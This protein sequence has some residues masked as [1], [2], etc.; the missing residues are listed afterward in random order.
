MGKSFNFNQLFSAMTNYGDSDH[1]VILLGDMNVC[2]GDT[3]DYLIDDNDSG[4]NLPLPED[5]QRWEKG[6]NKTNLQALT[7]KEAVFLII[8]SLEKNPLI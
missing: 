2:V 6:V 4:R 1:H 7:P 5:Y 3:F 8:F